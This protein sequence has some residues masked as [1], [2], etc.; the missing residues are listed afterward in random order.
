MSDWL[1]AMGV[2]SLLSLG[3]PC[4][5]RP[6]AGDTKAGTRKHQQDQKYRKTDGGGCA[7]LEFQH[8]EMETGWSGSQGHLLP[9]RGSEAT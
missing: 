6:L 8:S 9:P 3:L 2:S 4:T 7:Q 5:H 1:A